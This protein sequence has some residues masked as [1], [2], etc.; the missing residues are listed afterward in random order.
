M[1]LFHQWLVV[2]FSATTLI[3]A[4]VTEVLFFISAFAPSV[5]ISAQ[6]T[7]QKNL[8]IIITIVSTSGNPGKSLRKESKAAL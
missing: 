7:D 8:S 5:Q 2:R 3:C 6:Y 4:K 1:L